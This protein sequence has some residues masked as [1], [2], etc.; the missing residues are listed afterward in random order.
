[1]DLLTQLAQAG[2]AR[3]TAIVDAAGGGH[4]P[5]IASVRDELPEV[6]GD[7]ETAV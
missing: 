7:R 4:P 5:A 1:M 3:A 6:R 2:G